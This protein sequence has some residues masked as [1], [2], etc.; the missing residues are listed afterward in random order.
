MS[1]ISTNIGSN[2]S[3]YKAQL[4]S[5][6]ATPEYQAD[7][8][9]L[10][11]KEPE[12]SE[13]KPVSDSLDQVDNKHKE[14][15]KYD[16]KSFNAKQDSAENKEVELS[17]QKLDK[18]VDLSD[19]R[20]K[21]SFAPVTS[22]KEE[23]RE[24]KYQSRLYSKRSVESTEKL[25]P[26]EMTE[27]QTTSVTSEADQKQQSDGSVSDGKRRNTKG[28]RRKNERSDTNIF[29]GTPGIPF[30]RS[31]YLA[32]GS[33]SNE[34]TVDE[35]EEPVVEEPTVFETPRKTAKTPDKKE[36]LSSTRSLITDSGIKKRSDYSRTSAGSPHEHLRSPTTNKLDIPRSAKI[37]KTSA[38]DQNYRAS[39][40]I[41]FFNYKYNNGNSME[42]ADT[43]GT[44]STETSISCYTPKTTSPRAPRSHLHLTDTTSTISHYS[45]RVLFHKQDSIQSHDSFRS[46]SPRQGRRS[47]TPNREVMPALGTP[48]SMIGSGEFRSSGY[49]SNL[50][51]LPQTR[52]GLSRTRSHMELSKNDSKS[53]DNIKDLLD[54]ET[55]G[56]DKSRTTSPT[57]NQ[58]YSPLCV[59]SYSNSCSR[60]ESFDNLYTR[61]MPR[62]KK[63]SFEKERP[64]V[65]NNPDFYQCPILSSSTSENVTL[66]DSKM[67]D[68]YKSI[69]HNCLE[70]VRITRESAFDLISAS[71]RL[72]FFELDLRKVQTSIRAYDEHF[73]VDKRVP[74][75]N[76]NNNSNRT[77]VNRQYSIPTTY[78]PLTN[79]DSSYKRASFA[80]RSANSSMEDIMENI[81]P[82]ST[83][84]K[85]TLYTYS[86]KDR[87]NL[88]KRV[89]STEDEKF[90]DKNSMTR[91]TSLHSLRDEPQSPIIKSSRYTPTI[92]SSSYLRKSS[93]E[94]LSSV[95]PYISVYKQDRTTHYKA[96]EY[97]N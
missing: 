35:K 51:S 28:M 31:D 68:S 72:R 24:S 1:D 36:T 89:Q 10:E 29:F 93:K 54:T 92:H 44:T 94:S 5:F 15:T 60:R 22:P 25:P 84:G 57:S 78:I 27:K 47:S 4:R 55:T 83:S 34:N 46:P 3:D 17:S 18:T 59:T 67:G 64:T 87:F 76:H 30:K 39:N 33:Q 26:K 96:T 90:I 19:K 70:M 63:N 56:G 79:R 41:K 11:E 75:Y 8:I 50:S 73:Q 82:S 6:P 13:G 9:I 80:N 71:R 53:S 66:S 74:Q 23:R 95:P 12:I 21:S 49:Q 85:L 43:V 86:G 42:V 58:I 91:S 97:S 32:E 7:T 77:Y 20:E 40:L 81:S 48:L 88:R 69:N 2:M 62:I 38:N 65:C 45:D 14:E 61:T 52:N 37:S 16:T